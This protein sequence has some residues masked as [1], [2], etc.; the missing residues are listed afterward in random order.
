MGEEVGHDHAKGAVE[1]HSILGGCHEV[2][3]IVFCGVTV[4]KGKQGKSWSRGV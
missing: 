2:Y 3:G 4:K 1:L